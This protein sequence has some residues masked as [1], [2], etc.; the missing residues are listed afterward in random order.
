MIKFEID[1][2]DKV[3]YTMHLVIRVLTEYRT[4]LLNGY[5]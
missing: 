4:K 5:Q 3:I 2:I 1:M